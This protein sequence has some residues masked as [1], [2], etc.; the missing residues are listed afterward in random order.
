MRGVR[1]YAQSFENS[2]TELKTQTPLTSMLINGYLLIKL[3]HPFGLRCAVCVCLLLFNLV[4]PL[5]YT[6]STTNYIVISF[7]FS[8]LDYFVNL[9]LYSTFLCVYCNQT[10]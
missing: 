10:G 4:F 2:L 1:V 9:Y 6:T 7:S 5:I 3:V 8:L